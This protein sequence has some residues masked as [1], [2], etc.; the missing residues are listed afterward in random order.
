MSAA[1]RPVLQELGVRVGVFAALA[2][3]AAWQWTRMLSDPPAGRVALAVG[4]L[5]A[6]A[7]LLALISAS[8]L[9][10]ATKW[11]LAGIA[12]VV[13]TG[14]GLVAIGI[15]MRL[16][17]PSS[18]DD[19]GRELGRGFAGLDGDVDYPYD[20]K[21]DWARLVLLAGLPLALGL[22]A[23]FAFWPAERIRR[24]ARTL[25]LCTLI[26][27]CTV[28][29]TVVAP[30]APMLIGLLLV[31][32]VAAWLWL[33][34]LDRRDAV[35][36]GVLIAIAGGVA[37]GI[38]TRLDASEPWLNYESWDFAAGEAGATFDWD[39]GYGPLDWPREGE[40]LFT[41]KSEK[42]H[43]WRASVLEDFDGVRWERPVQAGGQRLEAPTQIEGADPSPVIE[44]DELNPDWIEVTRFTFGP[45]KSDLVVAPGTP[46]EVSGFE[47]LLALADGTTVSSRDPIENGDAYAAVSYVPDP[48]GEQMRSATGAY[49]FALTRYTQVGLPVTGNETA[50][51]TLDSVT[52]PL[53]GSDARGAGAVRERLRSSPYGEMYRLAQRLTEHEPTTYDAVRSV[54]A[55]LRDGPYTYSEA[56]PAAG[57][58][59]LAEFVSEDRTGYCQQFSGAMALMLRMVGI[60]A[61][62]VTGFSAGTRDETVS[63]RFL[64]TDFDAHSWVEVYFTGIGWVSFDP[65]PTAAPAM[66]QVGEGDFPGG[67]VPA[68]GFERRQE[69]PSGARAA[70]PVSGPSPSGGGGPWMALAIGLGVLG[71]AV[72]VPAA[73]RWRRFRSLPPSAA[74]E[75]QLRELGSGLERL[76]VPLSP[77][78]TLLAL[79]R[80]LRM[81]WK[82][83]TAGYVARLRAERFEAAGSA[84]PTLRD[85]RRVRRELGAPN[86]VP[87]R[88]QALLALPPGAPRRIT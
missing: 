2:A 9:P 62:V 24:G 77:G 66:S 47:G 39:H 25:G 46:V 69:D 29:A 86:G 26:A 76:G 22:A 11:A 57:A 1:Q 36:A 33:P 21:N 20:G 30:A 27:T 32:L 34:R 43:Y 13:S 15:P 44:M 74:A 54:R 70:D 6:G 61:R 10:R 42:P 75:A 12:A 73:L 53:R 52:V 51:G 31:A 59:P 55:H 81:R 50:G 4:V 83:L 72:A 67:G 58:F 8:G 65:T 82:P 3:L 37:V 64:V 38:A 5:A 79:E 23:A 71:L 68:E 63:D 85:R 88:V 49:P 18:W 60:P 80:K 45:L 35:A 17:E 7:A 28:G 41:V 14:A 48:T 87:G 40:T 16:L 56:V 78:E 84:V 19:L